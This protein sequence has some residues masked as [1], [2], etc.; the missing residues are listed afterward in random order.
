M[1][2]RNENGDE[3]AILVSHLRRKKR[4]EVSENGMKNDENE[5]E[6]INM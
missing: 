6:N 2:S 5:T 3:M 4:N 1:I